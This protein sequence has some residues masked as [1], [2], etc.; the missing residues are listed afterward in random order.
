MQAHAAGAVEEAVIPHVREYPD[1]G[2]GVNM[3]REE[4]CDLVEPGIIDPLKA[5]RSA[6]ENAQ[7]WQA[8]F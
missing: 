7:A 4:Y 8:F 3:L 5:T 1:I 2:W 6:L